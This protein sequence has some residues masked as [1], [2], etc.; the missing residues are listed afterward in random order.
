MNNKKRNNNLGK[1]RFKDYTKILKNADKFGFLRHL[2]EQCVD[3]AR[4]REEAFLR[5]RDQKAREKG[6]N[7]RL[8]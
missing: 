4:R 6:K 2:D 7:I 1:H 3:L 5:D 8:P